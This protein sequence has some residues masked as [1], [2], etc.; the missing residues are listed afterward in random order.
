MVNI[1]GIAAFLVGLLAL[2]NDKISVCWRIVIAAV[3][4]LIL[5]SFAL[6]SLIRKL[7][8]VA[9]R[10]VFV[11]FANQLD[12]ADLKRLHDK[13]VADSAFERTKQQR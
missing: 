9:L 7:T 8:R 10:G 13:K 12:L 4:I 3:V 6:A 11:A 2:F 1:I 5:V